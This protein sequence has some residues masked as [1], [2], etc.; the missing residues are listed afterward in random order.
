MTERPEDSIYR[1]NAGTWS[2][3]FKTLQ[4]WGENP[5]GD[6]AFGSQPWRLEFRSVDNNV[7]GIITLYNTCDSVKPIF[8]FV[9]NILKALLR[10]GRSAVT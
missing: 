3:T 8:E 6:R 5:C 10:I 2:W 7:T 9:L 1:P 4:T